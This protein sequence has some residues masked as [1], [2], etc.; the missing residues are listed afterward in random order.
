MQTCGGKNVCGSKDCD[1][2]EVEYL[3]LFINGKLPAKETIL[4]AT[5]IERCVNCKNI[6]ERLAAGALQ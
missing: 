3:N 2:M 4:A 6:Y 5:H 1:C